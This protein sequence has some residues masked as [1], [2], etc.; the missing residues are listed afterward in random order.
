MSIIGSL[1]EKSF[2]LG[3]LQ[4]GLVLELDVEDLNKMVTTRVAN[5]AGGGSFSYNCF[6]T[7]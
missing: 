3:A 1:S 6:N 2:P 4:T 5:D 7:Y